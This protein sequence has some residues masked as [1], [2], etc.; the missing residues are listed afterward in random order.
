MN[1]EEQPQVDQSRLVDAWQQTL[2]AKLEPGDKATVLPDGANPQAL[3]IHIDTAGRQ[4]YSFDFHCAYVDSR[5]VELNLI[6]VEK[7]GV[8][9]DE[10]T[11]VVQELVQNYV[12][13]IHECAQALHD[14]THH[15]LQ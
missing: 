1:Q 14:V 3:V 11:E 6:D 2:P 9:I 7:S 4:M 8:H 15:G 12:R 13:H 5:E 10:R